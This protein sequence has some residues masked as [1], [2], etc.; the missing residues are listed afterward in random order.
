M[1]GLPFDSGHVLALRV[2]P[3]GTFEPY[4]TLWH[5]TPAGSWS[6]F[7]EGPH[8]DHA[9]PRYYGSACAR[10]VMFRYRPEGCS[11]SGKGRGRRCPPPDHR[12][13]AP[14]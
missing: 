4:R 13:V 2:F 3:Q 12:S 9:C 7:V 10:T 11:P 14:C 1:F 8:L 5:R 6:I